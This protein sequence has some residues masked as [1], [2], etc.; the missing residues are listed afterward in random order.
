MRLINNIKL[1]TCLAFTLGLAGNSIAATK[2]ACLS[3]VFD[4]ENLYSDDSVQAKALASNYCSSVNADYT[5]STV[6]S[7]GQAGDGKYLYETMCC[8]SA[9]AKCDENVLGGS[10]VNNINPETVLSQLCETAGYPSLTSILSSSMSYKTTDKYNVFALCGG[11]TAQCKP[12][13]LGNNSIEPI[14]CKEANVKTRLLQLTKGDTPNVAD[15]KSLCAESGFSLLGEIKGKYLVEQNA[16]NDYY[17]FD[18]KCN[19]YSGAPLMSGCGSSEPFSDGI[20]ITGCRTATVN[21]TFTGARPSQSNILSASCEAAGYAAMD[22]ANIVQS[23]YNSNQFNVTALCTE[24]IGAKC[25]E[26]PCKGSVIPSSSTVPKVCENGQCYQN[27]CASF[28]PKADMCKECSAPTFTFTDPNTKNTCTIS[29]PVYLS[30]ES[31]TLNFFNDSHSGT[32]DVFCADSSLSKSNSGTCNKNC[33][34]GS[35]SWDGG[36]CGGTIPSGN[37]KHGQ[38]VTVSALTNS[39]SSTYQCANG[40]WQQSGTPQCFSS[41]SGN[42]SWGSGTSNSGVNKNNICTAGVG[43]LK[44]GSSGS[45]TSSKSG[46]SGSTNYSCSDGKV[47]LS[48]SSCNVSCSNATVYWDQFGGSPNHLCK[49]SVSA[50][51]HGASKSISHTGNPNYA[52][53]SS[54]ISGSISLACSDGR[55]DRSSPSCNYKNEQISSTGWSEY[56]RTCGSFTPSCSNT[57]QGQTFTQT[58]SCTVY[59]EQYVAKTYADGSTSSTRN[60]RTVYD[61]NTRAAIGCQAPEPPPPPPPETIDPVKAG[62]YVDTMKLDTITSN[63]CRADQEDYRSEGQ[64]PVVVFS[65]G[66][67]SYPDNYYFKQYKSE[68]SVV[69]TGDCTGTGVHCSVRGTCSLRSCPGLGSLNAV[70]TVTFRGKKTVF[71]VKAVDLSRALNGDAPR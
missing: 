44:H 47:S 59:E 17:S 25:T 67:A 57:L 32:V 70:A 54:N 51:L 23:K 21:K 49:G 52:L 31:A 42:I 28:T 5:G 63:H 11:N 34:G 26:D 9:D 8:D 1:V 69:W 30:G 16:D 36:T 68:Y 43:T 56:N 45:A 64:P 20:M 41:C 71:N 50:L 29:K 6:K 7:I 38:T 19:G 46:T 37:Y 53:G 60:T 66:N 39:G 33:S 58:Q 18:L 40:N 13:E 24:K 15:A 2:T 22:S 62:C 48:G 61:A 65:V 10:V 12:I 35:V 55:L 14:N 3:T 27:L 4:N